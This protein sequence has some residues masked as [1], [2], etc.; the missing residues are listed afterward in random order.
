MTG[1]E[2]FYYI[3][4]MSGNYYMVGSKNELMPAQDKNMASVFSGKEAVERV[5]SG[6][7]AKFYKIVNVDDETSEVDPSAIEITKTSEEVALASIG[8]VVP[9][10]E[11]YKQIFEFDIEVIDWVG[12]VKYSLFL[13]ET[14]RERKADLSNQLSIVDREILDLEHL[15]E[16]YILDEKESLKTL[17]M[18][19]DARK[20]RRYIKNEISR[21]DAF[22]EELGNS[23]QETR[24]RKCLKAMEGLEKQKYHPRELDEIF[25]DVKYKKDENYYRSYKKGNLERSEVFTLDSSRC[26]NTEEWIEEIEDV[27]IEILEADQDEEV[28]DMTYRE[29]ILDVRE[30]DWRDFLENQLIFYK[31]VEQYMI[32]LELDINQINLDIEDV[33]YRLEDSNLNV[34][35]GYNVYKQLRELRVLRKKKETELDKLKIMISRFD[36]KSM[37]DGYAETLEEYKE[38]MGEDESLDNPFDGAVVDD[39]EFIDESD[40]LDR[41]VQQATNVAV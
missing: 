32:N 26:E 40:N 29:T 9:M 35:Q 1:D 11:D 16:L 24:L 25:K 14:A 31:Y 6:K 15:V 17:A 5:G 38:Y 22:R 13:L 21:I 37:A 2:G 36:V 27:Q 30:Y 23:A 8:E 20:H 10:L 41:S 39:G 28:H 3:L 12:Y 33:M 4:D 19:K 7:K 18:I 34:T